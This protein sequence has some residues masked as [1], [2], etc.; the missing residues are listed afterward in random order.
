[1]KMTSNWWEVLR[2]KP[3]RFSVCWQRGISAWGMETFAASRRINS[4]TKASGDR[5]SKMHKALPDL[6]AKLSL[7]LIFVNKV[8][9]KNSHI[10]LRIY[11]M[12]AYGY[13]IFYYSRV[14]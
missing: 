13:Y 11:S 5:I 10:H 7:P 9:S 3:H 6:W 4:N 2:E 1:M 14:E 12:A 8:L